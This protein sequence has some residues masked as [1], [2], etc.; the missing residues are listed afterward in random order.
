MTNTQIPTW[1]QTELRGRY[2]KIKIDA[3]DFKPQDRQPQQPESAFDKMVK[4]E[5]L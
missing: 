2:G 1:I 3:M 5:E 4:E